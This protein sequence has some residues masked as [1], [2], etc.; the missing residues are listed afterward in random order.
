MNKKIIS[1]LFYSIIFLSSGN[2]V[3]AMK[4]GRD[5]KE[6][7]IEKEQP[8]VKKCKIQTRPI[9]S[10]RDIASRAS[11]SGLRKSGDVTESFKKIPEELG[12]YLRNIA[13][14]P[15]Y[16][17]NTLLH[18]AE[19]EHDIKTFLDLGIDPNSKNTDEETAFNALIS[20]GKQ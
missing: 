2:S 15:Q 12:E 7:E 3:L 1:L 9:E 5:E 19:N 6:K 8:D 14:K 17:K 13:Q 18:K 20:H 11:L 4:R 10:L 16:F